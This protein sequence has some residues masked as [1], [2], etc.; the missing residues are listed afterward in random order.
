MW[1]PYIYLFFGKYVAGDKEL[2]DKEGKAKAE[3]WAD[4]AD[5]YTEEEAIIKAEFW[6][7]LDSTE[8]ECILKCKWMEAM[9]A[10]NESDAC[11]SSC[12]PNLKAR[13][14]TYYPLTP[15]HQR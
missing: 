15:T 5:L 4:E 3:Y 11:Y 14:S 6:A 7:N 13:P 12:S 10:K 8:Y 9:N 2:S 1:I